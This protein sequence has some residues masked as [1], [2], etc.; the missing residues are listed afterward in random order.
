MAK[1]QIEFVFLG[2]GSEKVVSQFS[3][4]NKEIEKLGTLSN[5][6]LK[7][8]SAA[9]D[10][11][12]ASTGLFTSKTV[13]LSSAAQHLGERLSKGKSN[14]DDWKAALKSVSQETS[15]YNQLGQRQVGIL[16]AHAKVM[17][18]TAT[19]YAQHKSD[20]TDIGTRSKVLTQALIAQNAALQQAATRVIN[21]GKNTQWAGRQL[22]AGLTMPIALF[23]SSVAQT[24]NEVDQNLTRLARVYGIGL[25]TPT[26]NMLAG[27][28]KE[29]LGLARDLGHEL[30][31]S[32]QEVTDT[33]A[34]F[35]AAGLTGTELL[36]ATRQASRMVVL[37][38]TDKQ[39]AIKATIALQ[40]A[41]R[42]NT[43][44]V[45]EAT[46]F[47]NAAQAATSTS[48]SDLIESI[49]KV[50]PVIKGLG[51]SYKDMVAIVTA[52]KEGGVPASEAANA[53]KNSLGRIINPTKAAQN[54][55]KGFGIDINSIV[56]KNAGN[57]IGT[58]TDLQTG[59]DKLS[60]LDRQR[61]ISELFGKFQFARMAAFMDN[62]NKA[63]TQSAKV[64]EM[65]GMSASDLAAIADEQTKKIQESASGKFKIAVQDLRNALLPMGEAALNVF[66]SILGQVTDLIKSI[67][68]LPSP[69]K[70]A[71]KIFGG[72]SIIAGPLI[73]I[74]GLFANLIG[75]L[76]KFTTN[77]RTILMS[78]VTGVNPLKVLGKQFHFLTE[79]SVAEAKAA[80]LMGDALNSAISPAEMLLQVFREMSQVIAGNADE[81]VNI[82]S[83]IAKSAESGG[84][85]AFE[86]MAIS[87]NAVTR[88]AGNRITKLMP[89]GISFG[90]GGVLESGLNIPT[91]AVNAGNRIVGRKVDLFFTK[92]SD[93]EERFLK[94]K[95]PNGEYNE[96]QRS[97]INL[98]EAEKNLLMKNNANLTEVEAHSL[99]QKNVLTFILDQNSIQSKNV[100]AITKLWIKQEAMIERMNR[101]DFE[102]LTEVEKEKELRKA[103][104][105]ALR[106]KVSKELV[107]A[108]ES[109][110]ITR[111][112]LMGV[113][114]RAGAARLELFSK[115]IVPSKQSINAFNLQTDKAA[116]ELGLWS[117][118]LAKT[119]GM[120]RSHI[121][122][123]L[124]ESDQLDQDVEAKK[125]NVQA[126]KANTQAIEKDT[127][128]AKNETVARVTDTE[129]HAIETT[130]IV[131]DA[132]ATKLSLMQRLKGSKFA[133]GGLGIGLSM[134]GG[135]IGSALPEGMVGKETITKTAEFSGL[136]LMFG[137]YG[138]AAGAAIGAL[139]G[140][141]GELNAS[142]KKAAAALRSSLGV[143]SDE[144]TA[145]GI[146]IPQI[147]NALPEFNS[148]TEQATSAVENFRKAIQDAADGS[149]M[150]GYVDKLKEAGTDQSKIDAL[151]QQKAM[152][153]VLSGASKENTQ[154]AITA[155]MQEAGVT[156]TNFNV[157]TLFG[158]N[159]Q[160]LPSL[161]RDV[162]M[163][164]LSQMGLTSQQKA[165]DQY[166]KMP[167]YSPGSIP[168]VTQT[169]DFSNIE[170]IAES[171]AVPFEVLISKN[172]GLK[173]FLDTIKEIDNQNFSN[174]T[175]GGQALNKT[176]ENVVAD[177]PQLKAL[178]DK[179]KDKSPAERMIYLRAAIEN[180]GGSID[181]L[182]SMKT[183]DLQILLNKKEISDKAGSVVSDIASKIAESNASK[184]SGGS[185]GGT[186]AS[187]AMDKQIAANNKI[188]DQI[189]KQQAERKKLIDLQNKE[190]DFSKTKL[191][192]ENQIREALANGEYLKAAELRNELA[193]TEAK[194]NQEDTQTALDNADE[195]RIA[196]LEE[197][198]KVLEEK[199]SKA[200]SGGGGGGTSTDTAVEAKNI[201]DQI[202]SL[203][204]TTTNY[205]N[206]NGKLYKTFDEFKKGDA[207]KKFKDDMKKIYPNITP[208][209]LDALAR[210]VFGGY[211][212]PSDIL[213]STQDFKDKYKA[214][215]EEARSKGPLD[216]ERI[217]QMSEEALGQVRRDWENAK[218][219][220]LIEITPKMTKDQ[221]QFVSSTKGQNLLQ[222]ILKAQGG[223]ISGPGTGTSDSIPARLSNGEYVI[224]ATSVS[225]YGR[226]MLDSINSGTFNIPS[227][228]SPSFNM[229]RD[230]QTTS[231]SNA[232]NNV[233]IN[234][235]FK[236]SGTDP[237][238]VADEVMDRLS[239]MQ[240]KHGGR[241]RI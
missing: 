40:T 182:P 102:N 128:A 56:N 59:L 26:K 179:L 144:L 183:I 211:Y 169:T 15:L 112:Q 224:K 43:E 175:A 138:A 195:A 122:H 159:G 226:S 64:V 32:A 132:T 14:I 67:E 46:N 194:K 114:E 163:N 232:A 49:P 115:D 190:T 66:T 68:D 25:E 84:N 141:F 229:P 235:D 65:M 150:K 82:S 220:S 61:A 28:R 238:K 166:T 33:A 228:S 167:A 86:A 149:E 20:L 209:E 217:R 79:E 52:L 16:E 81:L 13:S 214:L 146:S 105:N 41:Y 57:L 80:N 134:A 202:N 181:G 6:Q 97:I 11:L 24:F 200:S 77:I 129:A 216:P 225:R 148:T 204:D 75:Q 91:E 31:I 160:R 187:K 3:T 100:T 17:G 156:R 206:T 110:T 73:M 236:I 70:T 58:L 111:E 197:K 119:I 210:K 21:W 158:Q 143:T 30:G 18:S 137:P 151:I 201:E 231:V 192:L 69:I 22:T 120:S 240:A 173:D 233:T 161:G 10:K 152:S 196:T 55:L 116:A 7:S 153:M 234:A 2:T 207:F 42:L 126:T 155:Y 88:G 219:R 95:G 104:N 213:R 113:A 83:A 9:Y 8:L 103:A 186:G 37:G 154:A 54:T 96:N 131:Q 29:V 223:Y 199:K 171:L 106:K 212:P 164:A 127:Q 241:V 12:I 170:K 218:I 60:S 1:A 198:N 189:K 94:P 188:I 176:L 227:V 38:E 27:V 93:V 72:I 76:G 117:E 178:L 165:V 62:F 193:V 185:S 4:L 177:D 108:A 109:G 36:G 172:T 130:A 140:A 208:A 147:T 50:G 135:M 139:I 205:I 101:E 53:I 90:Q 157:S 44:Q 180:V 99:A 23:G 74:T 51:G 174:T 145:L 48:M 239:T 107:A 237:K 19:V 133:M 63:G 125:K 92:L 5:S 89:T 118:E 230:I 85:S 162:T 124:A 136:G 98:I 221:I 203:I 87:G 47:F 39:E 121:L 34:Q 35:A 184:S 142:S 45:T 123:M 71:L 215:M 168:V 191:G 78:I 222:M